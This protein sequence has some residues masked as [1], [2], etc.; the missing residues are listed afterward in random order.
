MVPSP[1]FFRFN[2]SVTVKRSGDD[3][4]GESSWAYATHLAELGIAREEY[5]QGEE[6]CTSK[7]DRFERPTTG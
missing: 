3:E 5:G 2:L 6:S 1:S 4:L 7:P